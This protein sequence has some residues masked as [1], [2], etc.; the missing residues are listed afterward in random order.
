M[1]EKPRVLV[2]G[3]TGLIGTAV[4]RLLQDQGNE[5]VI[6][7][8]AGEDKVRV[9]DVRDLAAV[10]DAADGCEVVVHLAG[11]AGPELAEPSHGYDINAHGTFTVFQAAVNA[12]ARKIVYASSINANGLPLGSEA[13]LPSHYPYDEY[14]TTRIADWYSLSKVANEDAAH[15]ISTR[16]GIQMT[17]IRFPLVRDITEKQ[18]KTFAAH[19]R[20]VMD[21]APARAAA[22]GWSYLHVEDAARAVINAIEART[23]PAPGILVAAPTTFLEVDTAEAIARDAP[24]VPSTVA[25]RDVGLD[26]GRS[27]DWLGFEATTTLERVAP[28]AII[29]RRE[30]E[31]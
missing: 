22:E 16:H 28:H 18:G 12:G 27:A 24:G 11:I 29:S 30:W 6:F 25:G 31:A 10:T 21:T 13:V 20:S 3:G 7:D 23:P 17:G 19:I 2:T 4:V 5:A 8:L 14:E 15:M 9:G 1:S 26:L